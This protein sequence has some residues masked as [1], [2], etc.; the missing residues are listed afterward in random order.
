MPGILCIETSSTVCSVAFG[1]EEQVLS[2][3]E[4][5]EPNAHSARLSELISGA[6][7]DARKEFSD[8]DAVAVS[9]GPGSYTGLRIG[10]AAAK[11]ICYALDKPL[12]SV[13]TLRSMA[14]GMKRSDLPPG[15]F[16]CPMLDARR[17]E[18]YT[19]VF[20]QVC[21]ILKEVSAEIIGEDSFKQFLDSGPVVFAGEGSGKC[22]PVL[23]AHPNARF[24]DDFLLSASS[25][26]LLALKKF[27]NRE[28]EDLAYFEPYYLKDFVAG[29]PRVKG[30]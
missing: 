11:G 27:R 16:L 28:F 6:L 13:S 18:V 4:S 10:V 9:K 26:Y 8:I 14:E 21:N 7:H 20:D 22:K 29:K 5:F 3:R 23:G 12:I 15:A 30:I 25:L 1:V 24:L 17:M 2:V 19:A